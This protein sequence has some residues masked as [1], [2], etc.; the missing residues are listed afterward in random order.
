VRHAEKP[1]QHGGGAVLA[2]SRAIG[3]AASMRADAKMPSCPTSCARSRSTTRRRDETKA[4]QEGQKKRLDTRRRRRK[5]SLLS[6]AGG[7]GDT[8]AP[9]LATSSA[10]PVGY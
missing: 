1:G 9:E 5:N 8:S 3:K 6:L 7:L 10:R 4:S 2:G